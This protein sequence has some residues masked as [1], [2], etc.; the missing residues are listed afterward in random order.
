MVDKDKYMIVRLCSTSI[1]SSVILS[2]QNTRS[3]DVLSL[4]HTALAQMA[5]YPA[6]ERKPMCNASGALFG[7]LSTNALLA[8]VFVLM[9][10]LRI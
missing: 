10:L 5:K 4:A 1:H 9:L 3:A 8:S 2:R 7:H 6:H